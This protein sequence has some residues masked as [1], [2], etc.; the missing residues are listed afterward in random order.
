MYKTDA[1][2]DKEEIDELRDIFYN[3]EIVYFNAKNGIK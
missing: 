2:L 3:N 1:F